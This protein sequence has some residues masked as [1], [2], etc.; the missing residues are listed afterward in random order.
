MVSQPVG[1]SP[2]ASFALRVT[3]IRRTGA[4]LDHERAEI[5]PCKI[6]NMLR[7]VLYRR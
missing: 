7:L 6:L 3:A 2:G 5:A 1:T 4:L